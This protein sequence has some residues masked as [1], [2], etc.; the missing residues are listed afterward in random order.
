MRREL[1]SAR[2]DV[3]E[4]GKR[5]VMLVKHTMIGER[6]SSRVVERS[7]DIGCVQGEK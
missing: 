1:E 2:L 4:E 3:R 5:N 7:I 6:H